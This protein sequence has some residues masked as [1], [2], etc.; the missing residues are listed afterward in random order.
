MEKQYTKQT[1]EH[2]TTTKTKITGKIWSKLQSPSSFWFDN[3]LSRPSSEHRKMIKGIKTSK[4]HIPCIVNIPANTRRCNMVVF[5]S[6]HC[7]R[8]NVVGRNLKTTLL[9]RF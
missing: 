7:C 1:K 8:D 9:Q 6:R 2:Q 5:W 3:K 4:G